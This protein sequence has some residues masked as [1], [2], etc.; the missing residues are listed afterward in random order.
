MSGRKTTYKERTFY[1]HSWTFRDPG[2]GRTDTLAPG[3]YSWPFDVVLDGTMPESVEGLKDAYVVYRLKAEI[4]RKRAKDIVV[5]KPLRIVRTLGPSALELS[6]AMSVENI[7]PNK[8]E[9]SIVVPQKAV[10]FGSVVPLESRFT[11]LLKGLD[12]GEIKIKL[13]EIHDF[14]IQGP[15]QQSTKEYKKER[16]ELAKRTCLL[17]AAAGS[18]HSLVV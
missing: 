8:V 15:T 6:H 18:H 2:K 3:N 5:R 13:V 14:Y 7:W 12:L 9:Y 1:E 16:E 10:V 4:G 17:F 11:P